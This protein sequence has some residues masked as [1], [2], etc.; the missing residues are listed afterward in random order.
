MREMKEQRG[1][2]KDEEYWRR[3]NGASVAREEKKTR[4]RKG[5]NGGGNLM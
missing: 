2:Y 3:E 1:E 4:L 5:E